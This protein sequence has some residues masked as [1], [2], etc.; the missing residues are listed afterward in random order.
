MP[1]MFDTFDRYNKLREYFF[2]S[3]FIQKF[4]VEEI[5]AICYDFKFPLLTLEREFLGRFAGFQLQVLHV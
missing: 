2:Y 1:E 5:P 4:L 3:N